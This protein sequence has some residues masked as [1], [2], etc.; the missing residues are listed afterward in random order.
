MK[1]VTRY[2]VNRWLSSGIYMLRG[3]IAAYGYLYSATGCQGVMPGFHFETLD[4]AEA[5]VRK[6][7]EKRLITLEKQKTQIEKII[8]GL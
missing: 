3:H 7:A 6:M 4:E 8:A 5:K 1:Q 2:C